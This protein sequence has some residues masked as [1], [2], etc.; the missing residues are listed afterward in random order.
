MSATMLMI[1]DV[2]LV[3]KKSGVSCSIYNF[4]I[5]DRAQA[6]LGTEYAIRFKMRVHESTKLKI[7]KVKG[8]LLMELSENSYDICSM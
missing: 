2:S 5:A 6:F 1:K 3:Q 4:S 7:S 8:V